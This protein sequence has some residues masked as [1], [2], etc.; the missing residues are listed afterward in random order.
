MAPQRPEFYV[1]DD[2]SNFSSSNALTQRDVLYFERDTG[3]YKLGTGKRWVDTPY[4]SPG[5]DIRLD[6]EVL[7][8]LESK[9]SSIAHSLDLEPRIVE[10]KSAFN[11]DFGTSEDSAARGKHNHNVKDI[12]DLIIP[13]GINYPQTPKGYIL[14]D[15][16]SFKPIVVES[17]P[18]LKD[19]PISSKWAFE[20]EKSGLH[21]TSNQIANLHLPVTIAGPGISINGQEISLKIG[22]GDKDLCPNKHSHKEYSDINHIHTDQ[23]KPERLPA[24]S[25]N[26]KGAVPPTGNPTGKCLHDDGNWKYPSAVT[27]V[28]MSKEI[29]FWISPVDGKLIFISLSS[30]DMST[31][32]IMIN[33]KN[34]LRLPSSKTREYYNGHQEVDIPVS[35]GDIIEII[36]V[37]SAFVQ[38][39][40]VING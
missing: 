2:A 20:H 9:I 3:C 11:V 22:T 17:I 29:P 24:I 27:L 33:D 37:N 19:I 10:K 38:L 30:R 13:E 12:N 32:D 25:R 26:S 36:L 8:F 34:V 14:H 5:V 21:L 35:K 6:Q 15:D 7:A 18:S 28:Q 1:V 4:Y 16:K 39:G 23:V 40:V 31:V